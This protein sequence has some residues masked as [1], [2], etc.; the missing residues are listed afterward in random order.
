MMCAVL[1]LAN[2]LSF[3]TVVHRAIKVEKTT[4]LLAVIELVPPVS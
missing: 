1:E 4:H 2:Y 3:L